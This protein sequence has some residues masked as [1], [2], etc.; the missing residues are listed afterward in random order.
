VTEGLIS[1]IPDFSFDL[2]DPRR[3]G[4]T[5][6]GDR[7]ALKSRQEQRGNGKVSGNQF[8]SVEPHDGAP[9]IGNLDMVAN[10]ATP[11]PTVKTLNVEAERGLFHVE[12]QTI[13]IVF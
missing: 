5:Q 4:V 2:T 13:G 10:A 12:I 7:L 11:D 8:S 3:P 6:H 1:T 9:L